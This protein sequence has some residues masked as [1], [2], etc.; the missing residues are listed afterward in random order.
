MFVCAHRVPFRFCKFAYLACTLKVD[1]FSL[2]CNSR[3]IDH[4]PFYAVETTM[5]LA[6]GLY[7]ESS[8][9]IS[10]DGGGGISKGLPVTITRVPVY[11]YVCRQNAVTRMISAAWANIFVSRGDRGDGKIFNFSSYM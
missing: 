7:R 6:D 1:D 3:V 5:W 4:V 11:V 10:H 9:T 2:Y 8:H